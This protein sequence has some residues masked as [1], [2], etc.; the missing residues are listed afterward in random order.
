MNAEDAEA[1]RSLRHWRQRL[2]VSGSP[3]HHADFITA[4]NSKAAAYTQLR[5]T[6]QIFEPSQ[7]A[8]NEV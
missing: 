1:P 5:S 4:Q 2:E 8:A 7:P 3:G 6:T